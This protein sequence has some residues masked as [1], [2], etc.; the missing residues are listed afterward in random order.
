MWTQ[1]NF[2]EPRQFDW[3]NVG[4]PQSPLAVSTQAD[5]QKQKSVT[6]VTGAHFQRKP[7]LIA[8]MDTVIGHVCLQ[9]EV[10]TRFARLSWVK[11]A[12]STIKNGR[13]HQKSQKYTRKD[14]FK[15]P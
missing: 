1:G 13:K 15:H 11:H 6:V 5:R 3:S 7:S 4:F 2:S 14:T 8:S 10:R 12:T 9:I